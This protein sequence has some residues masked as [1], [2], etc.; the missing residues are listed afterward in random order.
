MEK[1]L[2]EVYRYCCSED[3]CFLLLCLIMAGEDKEGR[4]HEPQKIFEIMPFPSQIN[5]LF[6]VERALQK[7]HF[8]VC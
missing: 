7:L 1:I 2:W 4:G 6:D 5:A 3:Q 8:F